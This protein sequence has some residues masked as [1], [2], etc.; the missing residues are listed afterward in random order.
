MPAVENV[1]RLLPQ[2]PCEVAFDLDH[3]LIQA[4]LAFSD[5]KLGDKVLNFSFQLQIRSS[6]CTEFYYNSYILFP[7]PQFNSGVDQ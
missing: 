5:R 2:E 6:G 4:F 1:E 3:S 7:L